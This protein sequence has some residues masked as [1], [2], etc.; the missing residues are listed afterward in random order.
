[1]NSQT[2]R[3]IIRA[4]EVRDKFGGISNTTLHRYL[5]DG[6]IPQ[7]FKIGR[8]NG[9]FSDDIEAALERLAEPQAA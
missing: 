8:V 4:A 1:M 2:D 9:W 3:R 7:P 6:R 5:S